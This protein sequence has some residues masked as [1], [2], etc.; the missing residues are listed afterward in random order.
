MQHSS[1]TAAQPGLLAARQPSFYLPYAKQAL[2]EAVT[3]LELAIASGS[4]NRAASTAE[5]VIGRAE[6][7]IERMRIAITQAQANAAVKA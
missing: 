1:I 2:V 6:Y 4:E 7:A 5:F 3:D